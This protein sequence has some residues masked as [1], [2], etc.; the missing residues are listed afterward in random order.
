MYLWFWPLFMC[1]GV[2]DKKLPRLTGKDRRGITLWQ[3]W[4]ERGEG[5]DWQLHYEIDKRGVRRASEGGREQDKVWN[6][7][8]WQVEGVSGLAEDEKQTVNSCQ[9]LELRIVSDRR[10][11][12]DLVWRTARSVDPRV[13]RPA[14]KAQRS[15]NVLKEWCGEWLVTLNVEKFGVMHMR[16]KGVRKSSVCV[17]E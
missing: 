1:S 15:R 12:V 16:K 6:G 7:G 5:G 2:V 13:A 11:W 14:I 17:G 3:V 4:T 9:H 10:K 8:R